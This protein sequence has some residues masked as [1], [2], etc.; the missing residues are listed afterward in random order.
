MCQHLCGNSTI[1]LDQAALSPWHGVVVA[2][3]HRPNCV[4]A[5]ERCPELAT[6]H[7]RFINLLG[8]RFRCHPVTCSIT[9]ARLGASPLRSAELFAR[10]HRAWGLRPCPAPSSDRVINAEHINQLSHFHAQKPSVLNFVRFDQALYFFSK[11]LFVRN[12]LVQTLFVTHKFKY[13]VYL[14]APLLEF[15]L[16]HMIIFVWL[17]S[18]FVYYATICNMLT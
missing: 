10:P 6:P 17:R 1:D 9:S 3:L 11:K 7:R 5:L 2:H 4:V 8:R 14:G 15:F 16:L 18:L 13:S 12:F